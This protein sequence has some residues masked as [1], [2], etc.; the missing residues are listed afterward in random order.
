[1]D[2]ASLDQILVVNPSTYVGLETDKYSS[3]E[4]SLR[5]FLAS[6]VENSVFLNL[7]MF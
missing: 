6:A 2:L 5:T 7:L 1:M 3:Y 4:L